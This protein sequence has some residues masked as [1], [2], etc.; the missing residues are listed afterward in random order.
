[1]ADRNSPAR[2][3]LMLKSSLGI[4]T[5]IVVTVNSVQ[6]LL[7]DCKPHSF[8]S[9]HSNHED[10][11]TFVVI[12]VRS[13]NKITEEYL[14]DFRSLYLDPDD[15]FQP[16]FLLQI[17][18]WGAEEDVDLQ[19]SALSLLAKWNTKE[20][21]FVA[22]RSG[23]DDIAPGPYVLYRGRICEPW[24]VYKDDCLSMMISFR[25]VR[26]Y[27][28]RE[29]LTELDNTITANQVRMVVPSRSYSIKKPSDKPLAG[30][31]IAVKD[32]FDIKGFK[33]SLC[34]RAWNEYHAPKSESARSVQRLQDLVAAVVGKTR[35]NA[36]IVR[37]EAMECVEFLAP[38]NPRGD[39]Y[40]TSSGSSSGSCVAVAA[41]PWLDFTL[42]SDTNGSCRKPA[43]RMGCFAIRP[44]TGVLDMHGIASFYPYF[45][46]SAFFGRDISR[47]R[48]FANLW[49]GGSPRLTKSQVV[50]K[51]PATIIYP[52]DYLPTLNKAQMNLIDSFVRDLEELLGVNKTENIFGGN[53]AQSLSTICREHRAI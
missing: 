7:I 29:T 11:T 46:V 44:T 21:Y 8:L 19:P 28:E 25:P 32:I 24:R 12:S 38:F 36:M 13:G 47:F 4:D 51:V 22:P 9:L 16:G 34:N 48:E 20:R 30:I 41:Y 50:S 18:F 43:Y 31:R 14:K 15:I 53:V 1:M 23:K 40:Q 45:D 33:T 5:E 27:G 42:G 3:V 35:L 10:I 17:V 2:D 39:G 26:E 6:Y 52:L 49:Y 37:E